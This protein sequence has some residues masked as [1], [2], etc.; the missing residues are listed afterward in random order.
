MKSWSIAKL[1]AALFAVALALHL[2]VPPPAAATCRCSTP[3][4]Q[5]PTET[6]TGSTC[7]VAQSNLNLFLALKETGCETADPCDT[8]QT[9]TE[10]CTQVG[11]TFQVQ[12]YDNYLC[13]LGTTCP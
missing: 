10:P 3:A 6:A 9:I 13:E 1:A 7:A 11:G 8:V 12:G 5:T 4:H 2:T